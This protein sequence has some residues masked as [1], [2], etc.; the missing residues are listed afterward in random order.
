MRKRI[1]G[2][3][4][5]AVLLLVLVGIGLFRIGVFKDD[6]VRELIPL[7]AVPAALHIPY[8]P[9]LPDWEIG[10]IERYD[11]RFASPTCT[12]TFANGI[13]LLLSTSPVTFPENNRSP[14]IQFSKGNLHYAFQASGEQERAIIENYL[15]N[16]RESIVPA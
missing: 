4:A 11:D 14:V 13:E 12:V 7:F 6:T 16:V 5:G 15:E 1:V 8:Q 10:K 3:A 2:I 9:D